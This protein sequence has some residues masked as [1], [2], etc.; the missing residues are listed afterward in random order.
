KPGYARRADLEDR[1]SPLMQTVSRLREIPFRARHFRPLPAGA[2]PVAD[3]RQAA[4]LE[5]CRARLVMVACVFA[6]AFLVVAA[7]LLTMPLLLSGAGDS[8]ARTHSIGPPPPVRA[9]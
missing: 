4:A 1:R 8:A 5:T 9:D 2:P 3:E 7:R 6:V